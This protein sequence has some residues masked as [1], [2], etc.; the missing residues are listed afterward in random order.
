MSGYQG[1]VLLSRTPTL[2][3]ALVER[4]RRDALAAPAAGVMW[5]AMCDVRQ[6]DC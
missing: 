4:A 6:Q 1:G 2:D 5:D 3:A